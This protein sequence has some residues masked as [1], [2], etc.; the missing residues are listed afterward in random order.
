MVNIC[1]LIGPD[2]SGKTSAAKSLV[3][4]LSLVKRLV[5]HTSRAM[6]DGEVD[7]VDYHFT[8]IEEMKRMSLV[9]SEMIDGNLY[10]LS[11]SELMKASEKELF[12]IVVLDPAGAISLIKYLRD[13]IAL[14]SY[15]IDLFNL[16]TPHDICLKRLSKEMDI[17]K[18]T[19]R[20][21]RKSGILTDDQRTELI[22]LST[23]KS[24][25]VNLYEFND[26]YL[27]I[28]ISDLD[29]ILVY[30]AVAVNMING[31]SEIFKRIE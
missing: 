21:A 23:G 17:V 26:L 16:N 30:Q 31:D 4:D 22:S 1:I 15:R 27:G 28:L 3:K 8:T 2:G 18:A 19:K 6:R 5:T 12:W 11:E 25:I 9:E 14:L 20:L 29:D 24:P 7:G 10:G 13:N